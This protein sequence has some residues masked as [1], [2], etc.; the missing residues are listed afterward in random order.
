MTSALRTF[1]KILA[2]QSSLGRKEEQ[3]G[4]GLLLLLQLQDNSRTSVKI[5]RY[6]HPVSTWHRTR[7]EISL[8]RLELLLQICSGQTS[9]KH[10]EDERGGV[11]FPALRHRSKMCRWLVVRECDRVVLCPANRSC[12]SPNRGKSLPR[13]RDGVK[14]FIVQARLKEDDYR[15]EHTQFT[16]AYPQ[17]SNLPGTMLLT[18]C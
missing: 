2:E 3:T 7:V 14:A 4:T 18:T 10:R 8:A 6:R 15:K 9:M 17:L 12:S 16:A 11:G 1:W 5:N 13:D